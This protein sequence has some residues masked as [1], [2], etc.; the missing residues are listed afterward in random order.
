MEEE[1]IK[2][3]SRFRPLTVEESQAIIQDTCIE[4]FKKGT[5]LLSEGQISKDVFFILKG[6][7]RQFCISDG[8]EKNTDFFIEQEW[9]LTAVNYAE[10]TPS[11]FYLSCLEDC[12]LVVGNAENDKKLYQNFPELEALARS[13]M[14]V[15]MTKYKETL[16]SYITNSPEQRYINL[17]K[18]RPEL[19]QRVPQHHLASYLGIKPESLSRIRKRIF[20]KNTGKK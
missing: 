6:C 8:D 5:I 14:E 13:I 18:N 20:S 12:I 4:N 17:L 1:F 15:E 7:V 11:T 10:K 9:V 19:L 2:Y 16:V 3:F